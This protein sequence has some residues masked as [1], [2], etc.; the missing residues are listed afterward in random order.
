MSKLF[1]SS[2]VIHRYSVQVGDDL[3]EVFEVGTGGEVNDS[4]RGRQP[5]T[6]KRC[7]EVRVAPPGMRKVPDGAKH[8]S[9]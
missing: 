5:E 3:H 9:V 1:F 4:D 2:R 8:K 6:D 7:S